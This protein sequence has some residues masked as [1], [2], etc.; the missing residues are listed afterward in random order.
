MASDVRHLYRFRH[1][2]ANFVKN[3]LRA[4]YRRS[5]LGFLWSLLNP[6]ITMAVTATVFALILRFPLRDFA[7]YVFSGLLPWGFMS[8]AI[9][10]GGQT[11]ILGEAYLKKIYVPKSMFPLIT[12][13]SEAVNFVLSLV[14]LYI[15]G[16]FLFELEP[17]WA[18]VALPLASFWMML[19]S[20]GVAIVL[21]VATVYFRDLS[22]ITQVVFSVVFYLV[23]ILYPL[24][25]IPERYRTLFLLNPFY[26]FIQMFRAIIY[27]NRFPTATEWAIPAALAVAA[28]ALGA[29]V[30]K[31]RDR[32]LIFRL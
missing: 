21:A 10:Q 3:A 18:L 15:L 1:A 22:H 13:L 5:A 26:H 7:V 25:L 12:T 24:D 8:G 2:I 11:I 29:Y 28:L 20:L 14:S 9:G 31:S 4:R 32:D 23:P 17:G 19:F 16:L 27:E 30:L 6:L